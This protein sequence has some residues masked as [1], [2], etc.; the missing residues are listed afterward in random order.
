[1]ISQL[2]FF[3]FAAAAVIQAVYLFRQKTDPL[4]LFLLPAGSLLLFA[5]IIRRSIMIGFPAVTNT[6]E[7]L[8]FFSA[9]TGAILSVYRLRLALNAP[10]RAAALA[11]SARFLL[12]GGSIFVIIL[13]ALASSPLAPS[14]VRPPVPA[15]RSAWLVLH[16]TLAFI[17]EA[18][19]AVSFV[20]A[21]IYLFTSDAEKQQSLDRIIYTTI[22][23][24]YP[25]FTAGALIFGAIWAQYAW[26]RYWGWD[27]KETWALVTWLVYTLYLHFRFI[28]R[29]SGRIPAFIAVIG[30]LFTLFTFLGV[31]FLLSGKHSYG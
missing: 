5:A 21:L 20:A 1:M 22:A 29:K 10:A 26:G 6:F 4:S 14:T 9:A 18:F 2:G 24:G 23:V 19:F 11:Q 3:C 13:L 28:R 16:V 17:G 27:P 8:L 12:F 15:L 7:S 31:N 30:F 25:V